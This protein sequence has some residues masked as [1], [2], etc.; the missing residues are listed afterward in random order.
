[1]R[2]NSSISLKQIDFATGYYSKS[3]N[4]HI[5]SMN[6]PAPVVHNL[7]NNAIMAIIFLRNNSKN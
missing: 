3:L 7:N 4:A 1:M 6:Q 2:V 5:I